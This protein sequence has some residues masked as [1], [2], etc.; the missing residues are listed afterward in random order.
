MVFSKTKAP[1]WYWIVSILAFIWYAL[2]VYYFFAQTF[3][4][5]SYR[6]MYSPEQLMVV[7]KMPTWAIVAFGVAVISGVFGVFGLILRKE[8][9]KKL[10]LVSFFAI[11]VQYIYNVFIGKMYELFSLA[12]NVRYFIIPV[13]AFLLYYIASNVSQRSWFKQ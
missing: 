4:T 1:V 3:N 6:A 8:W 12:E 7:D 2:G 11:V 13:I 5:S 9:T 10:F